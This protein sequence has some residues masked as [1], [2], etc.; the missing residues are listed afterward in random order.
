ML[1]S[2]N[3]LRS[4]R[5]FSRVHTRGNTIR[6]PFLS[7]RFTPNRLSVNRFGFLVGKKVSKSAVIRRKVQR[8]LREAV[9][10]QHGTLVGGQDIVVLVRP[11]VVGRS[12]VQLVAELRELFQRAGFVGKPLTRPVEP[13]FVPPM[14]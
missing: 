2:E 13:S 3:R 4:D 8:R 12:Y 6:G 9:R 10:A 14:V 11:S 1:S 7:L 5:D